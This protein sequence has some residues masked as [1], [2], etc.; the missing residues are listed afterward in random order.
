M[1]Q[2]RGEARRREVSPL[3]DTLEAGRGQGLTT[4]PKA[5]DT[6]AAEELAHPDR[7]DFQEVRYITRTG[8]PLRGEDIIYVA[9]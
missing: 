9:H 6:T 7:E 4:W 2:G 3:E 5:E 8:L 1:F